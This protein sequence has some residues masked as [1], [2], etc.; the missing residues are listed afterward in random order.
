MD[1]W[2]LSLV[3]N[4]DQ[5][6]SRNWKRPYLV[7]FISGRDHLP[8]SPHEDFCYSKISKQEQEKNREKSRENQEEKK[9]ENR[10]LAWRKLMHAF[11]LGISC[12]YGKIL[13]PQVTDYVLTLWLCIY[14]YVRGW[15]KWFWS[16]DI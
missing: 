4:Y 7:S 5:D 13:P 10:E 6:F 11:A 1:Q 3:L 9:G 2:K 8:P 12:G 14:D 15:I 16:L